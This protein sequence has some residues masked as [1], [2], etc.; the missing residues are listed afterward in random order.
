[1]P[2]AGHQSDDD[3]T[4]VQ[5]PPISTGV[6]LPVAL[7]RRADPG[8]FSAMQIP[9]LSGRFFTSDDRNGRPNT[10]V[11]NRALVQ[12][13]FPGEN[14]VGKHLHVEAEN[15]GDFEIVGVVADTLYQVGRPA[16]AA[17]YFPI[18]EGANNEE[19]PW[20]CAGRQIR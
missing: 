3:F 15:N 13:Y 11:V 16:M 4:I 17:M 19:L 18:L 20:W 2:G 8:F 5:H 10:V 12:Q 6:A 14:P 9:L 7:Y 1:M